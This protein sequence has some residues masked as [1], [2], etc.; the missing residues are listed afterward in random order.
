LVL[1]PPP[2]GYEADLVLAPPGT[3]RVARELRRWRFVLRSLRGFDVVHFNFGS[4]LLP[5][6]HPEASFLGRLYG[7][8]VGGRDLQLLPKRTAVFVTYQGDDAR[9]AR[10]RFATLPP[11]YYDPAVDAAKRRSIARL[12]RRAD[13]VYALNPDLLEVLPPS[14]TFLPYASVDLR[15]WT[16]V[17]AKRAKLPVVVHAPTDRGVKGT[18]HLVRAV[19]TLRSEGLAIDLVL[20]E[21]LS[22]EQ[23]RAV[24]ERADIIVDQLLTG[25]YGGL[26]VEGMALGK[27]VVAHIADEDLE[28]VPPDLSRE[29]PVVRATT[30]TI[31]TVLRE[32]LSSRREQLP[33]IGL[34]GRAFVER[35]HD[36][37]AVAR[38]TSAAYL[39]AVRARAD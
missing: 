8:L 32:L 31:A 22:R 24:Y 7:S 33:D 3:S 11:G 12:A 15:T 28:H 38:T 23:A 4:T 27:P 10:E 26:A 36:P 25:W 17:D 35:W 34:R 14:A 9:Q 30:E 39:A 1:E 6:A 16:P 13:G 21:G 29:L 19:D 18:E 37:L 2:Y 20:V 5:P